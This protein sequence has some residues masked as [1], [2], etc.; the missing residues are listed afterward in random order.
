MHLTLSSG[1]ILRL[2]QWLPTTSLIQEL[3]IFVDYMYLHSVVDAAV[4]SRLEVFRITCEDKNISFD[5]AVHQQ[6]VL[7]RMHLP[8]LA[9]VEVEISSECD[10]SEA[11][12]LVPFASA[13][14]RGILTYKIDTDIRNLNWDLD[15]FS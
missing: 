2:S 12:L 1:S 4:L 3:H 7:A 6:D 11:E 9:K 13:A 5:A 15:L 8:V 14:R 10:V